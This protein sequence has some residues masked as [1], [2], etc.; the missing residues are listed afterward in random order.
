MKL[1]SYVVARDYGFAPNPFYEVCTL[2][3]CK[4]KIRKTA[5]IGDWIIGTGSAKNNKTGTLVYAM[6]VKKILTYNQYWDSPEFDNK[7]PILTSSKKQAFGDNIY[8]KSSDAWT[9]AN[10]H[11][12]YKDGSANE[13]NIQ[14][15]TKTDRVL[16]GY[17]YV[18]FGKNAIEIPERFK[19]HNNEDICAK[20]GH[21]CKFSKEF[22]DRVIGWVKDLDEWGY[23]GEPFD[24]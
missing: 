1:F 2:A 4:P 14:N 24:W 17:N 9:Q 11:H 16:I 15:D 21:K 6:N 5:N 22:V 7:K 10:S 18:Y 13:Y 23:A 8:F 3:T 12:S 19:N 20:R